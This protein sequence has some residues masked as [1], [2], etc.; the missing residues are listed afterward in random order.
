MHHASKTRNTQARTTRPCLGCVLGVSRALLVGVCD[1]GRE[2][3]MDTTGSS[4]LIP[5]R[6]WPWNEADCDT[7][8]SVHELILRW[9]MP[10][11][12]LIE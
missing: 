12:V 4:E 8:N 1:I 11:N 7:G 5:T 10:F 3:A 6:F 9:V 2:S